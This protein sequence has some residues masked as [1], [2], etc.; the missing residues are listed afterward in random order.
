MKIRRKKKK[1]QKIQWS[2]FNKY[3]G[4]QIMVCLLVASLIIALAK[5]YQGA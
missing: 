4:W 5:M 3:K 1:E 2:D